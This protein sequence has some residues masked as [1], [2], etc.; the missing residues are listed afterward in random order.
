MSART[1]EPVTGTCSKCNRG[2]E[3]LWDEYEKEWCSVC[4]WR[5]PVPESLNA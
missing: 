5:Y 3:F 1:E 4:C 2:A